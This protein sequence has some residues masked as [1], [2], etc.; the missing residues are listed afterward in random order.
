MIVSEKGLQ[1]TKD[2][3]VEQWFNGVHFMQNYGL[4]CHEFMPFKWSDMISLPQQSIQVLKAQFYLILV[5][6]S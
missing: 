3:Y 6:I 5:T 4:S 2:F 1:G